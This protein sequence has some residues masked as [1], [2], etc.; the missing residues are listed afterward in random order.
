[1]IFAEL[2]ANGWAFVIGAFF[3]GVFQVL[4][5]ILNY[6]RERVKIE[7]D[8]LVADRVEE[9]RLRQVTV[10]REVAT[11]ARKQEESS[12]DLQE[13]IK[14]KNEKLE[15]IA[16]NVEVVHKATNKIKDE[17]M[18]STDKAARAEGYAAGRAEAEAKQENKP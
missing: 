18:A 3:V 17:L 6:L 14:A 13:A 16:E 9:V 10:A 4:T 8:N 1:M 2:D 12:L 7:R 11:V 5:I 15:A